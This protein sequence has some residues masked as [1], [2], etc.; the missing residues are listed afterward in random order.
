MSKSKKYSGTKPT[1]Q[2]LS[3]HKKAIEMYAIPKFPSVPNTDNKIA[4]NT[5]CGSDSVGVVASEGEA[6]FVESA[7][8]QYLN[9][10]IPPADCEIIRFALD[11][12]VELNAGCD[13]EHIHIK[14]FERLALFFKHLDFDDIPPCFKEGA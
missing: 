12:A 11:I 8:P 2:M 4:S 10:M 6:L 5:P 7:T 14:D 9:L 1:K 3:F 13:P